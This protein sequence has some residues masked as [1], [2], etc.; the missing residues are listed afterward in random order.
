MYNYLV[1]GTVLLEEISQKLSVKCPKKCVEITIR[2]IFKRHHLYSSKIK[3]I[4]ILN[5]NKILFQR[6]KHRLEQL[7]SLGADNPPNSIKDR[8]RDL[9]AQ[10]DETLAGLRMEK[11]LVSGELAEEESMFEMERDQ[12]SDV[13]HANRANHSTD[14]IV[15][16][17]Q[18][19]ITERAQRI[20]ALKVT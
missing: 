19:T 6:E 10:L 12:L 16:E 18:R 2:I 4:K 9:E 15:F 14:D 5:L 3:G 11:A 13:A 8:I 1:V 20:D 7:M 17:L